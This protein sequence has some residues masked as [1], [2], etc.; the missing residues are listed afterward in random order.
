LF[1]IFGLGALVG[2][3]IFA[4]VRLTEIREP[5]V[6]LAITSTPPG[7]A[8][9]LDGREIGA[10][11]PRTVPSLTLLEADR[12]HPGTGADPGRL[13]VQ[14]RGR[15]SGRTVARSDT[16]AARKLSARY[17]RKFIRAVSRRRT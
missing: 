12:R 13:R 9:V 1:F 3:V 4:I 7:A 16:R 11:T 2:A 8:I 14:Q 6:S 5:S 10:E 17:E 15:C